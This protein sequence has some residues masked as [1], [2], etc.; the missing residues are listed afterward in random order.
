MQGR[1]RCDRDG[2]LYT[3]IPQ[4]GNWYVTVD[5]EQ[6]SSTLV[7]DCMVAVELTQGEHTVSFTYRNAA[8]SLGWK[9]SLACGAALLALVQINYRPDWK[10][11]LRGGGKPGKYQK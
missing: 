4:N 2:L 6:V 7:G 1:I 5:G 8:F 10:K 9:I 3:S 11:L